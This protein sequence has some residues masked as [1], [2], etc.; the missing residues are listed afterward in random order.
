EPRS[1]ALRE[2]RVRVQA[3]ANRGTAERDL[4]DS[5]E[6]RLDARDALSNLRRIATELLAQR[7][8]H[9]VPQ[10][11]APRLDDVVELGRLGIERVRQALQGGDEVVCQLLERGEMDGRGE[12][13]VRRLARVDVVVRVND[14]AS[15]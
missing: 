9:R 2:L 8:G 10:M 14:P 5:L 11:R 7:D 4:A 12:D 3:C 13:V 1:D 15:A 6:R